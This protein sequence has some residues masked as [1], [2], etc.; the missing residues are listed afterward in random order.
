MRNTIM[1]IS[2]VSALAVAVPAVAQSAYPGR[3]NAYPGAGA[4]V[5][6]SSRLEQLRTR[7]QAGVQ[8]GSINRQEA[9]PLRQQLR[10]LTLLERRYA[11]GGVTRQERGELQSR[12][13]DLRQ[14]IR[15]ADGNDQARWDR[16]DRQDGYGRYE[17]HQGDGGRYARDERN[18]YGDRDYDRDSRPDDAYGDGDAY[19]PRTQPPR[20]GLG[21]VLDSILGGGR[22]RSG[23]Q[24]PSGLYGLPNGY[25][26]QY[27]D[28]SDAYYR[29][30]GRQIYQIDARTRTVVQVFPMNR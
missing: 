2:A 21:G 20:G 28:S 11:S 23:Q 10:Q 15:R 29:T 26:D 25:R 9:V 13:R 24:A 6:L 7:L 19:Q 3:Q 30:D 1:L 5:N 16:Y 14:A 18:D 17:G 22:A 8:S 27:R 12:M 4:G